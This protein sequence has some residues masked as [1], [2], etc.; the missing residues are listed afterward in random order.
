MIEEGLKVGDEYVAPE[1]YVIVPSGNIS[2][3]VLPTDQAHIG[4]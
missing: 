1:G 3:L 2:D 4:A